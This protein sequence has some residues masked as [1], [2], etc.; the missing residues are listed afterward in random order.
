MNDIAAEV[1]RMADEAVLMV[2]DRTGEAPDFSE[3]SL[4]VIEDT[5][6][7]ASRYFA[8]LPQE[9]A[10][11]LVQY[12]GCYLLEVA[13]HQ[14]GGSYLWHEQRNQPVL[15]VGEPKFHVAIITWDKVRGRLSGDKGDN[16][17]F[18]FDGFAQRVRGAEPGARA[19]YI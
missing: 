4:G 17:S 19:L 18:F 8:G 1:A 9:Q 15:V 11:K 14:F 7:E 12:F 10:L 2:K 13:R 5:L 16:V 6:D 3:Q